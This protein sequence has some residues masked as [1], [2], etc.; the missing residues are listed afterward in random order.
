MPVTACA[1]E[2]EDD[3]LH[4][5]GVSKCREKAGTEVC[6]APSFVDAL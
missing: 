4:E 5:C 3:S 2:C 6:C 1:G